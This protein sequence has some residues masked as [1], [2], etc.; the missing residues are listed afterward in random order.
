MNTSATLNDVLSNSTEYTKIY[1]TKKYD[2]FG[3]INAN[4]ELVKQNL[5]RIRESIKIKHIKAECLVV[6][7]DP[8]P[9]DGG[10]L[11]I[12]DGQHRYHVLK[13]L[14]LPVTYV[15]WED[16]D[17]NV[18]D[19]SLGDVE[20][21]NTASETWDISA[22]MM[23]KATLGVKSYINYLNL[24]Q[25]HKGRFEHEILFYIINGM[26]GRTKISYQSFKDGKLELSDD[27]SKW[28]QSKL[29]F[30]NLFME[31]ISKQEAGKRYYLK[32]LFELSKVENL[33]FERLKEK[34][35]HSSWVPQSSKSIMFS[36]DRLRE[37]YN[38]GMVKNKIYIYDSGNGFKIRVE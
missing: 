20:R 7:F 6:G 34:V 35:I 31:R 38:K 4:R 26:P 13:E 8:N 37:V 5:N 29:D 25:S 10:P 30:L 32:A 2:L 12:I 24:K 22:F 15:I 21:L 36:L 19:K 28:V 27:D 17:M 18:L 23:S 1:E 16:F 9:T 33:N 14:G 11:K 3:F